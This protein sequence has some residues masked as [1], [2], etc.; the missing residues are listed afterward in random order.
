MLT[1]SL[2]DEPEYRKQ[3]PRHVGYCRWLRSPRQHEVVVSPAVSFIF[4]YSSLEVEK[5]VKAS[6]FIVRL[7]DIS[8]LYWEIAKKLQC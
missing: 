8:S 6:N 5:E 2:E 7:V 4:F 1:L 3:D